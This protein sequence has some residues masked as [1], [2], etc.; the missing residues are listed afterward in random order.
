[1]AIDTGK[2]F[3]TVPLFDPEVS[4]LVRAPLGDGPGWWA[5]APGA[6]FD[7]QS[8]TF[9]LVYRQRQPRELGRGVELRIAASRRRW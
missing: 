2:T 6:T 1:M 8:N 4:N 5:G 9:Y 3:D 7:A